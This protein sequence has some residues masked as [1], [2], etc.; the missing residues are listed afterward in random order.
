MAEAQ[1]EIGDG[2]DL[3][4][5]TEDAGDMRR[6]FLGRGQ[7]GQPDR[8]AHQHGVHAETRIA[9][10]KNQQGAG[11]RHFRNGATRMMQG[12]AGA[13]EIWFGRPRGA[14]CPC[15]MP[16]GTHILKRFLFVLSPVYPLWENCIWTKRL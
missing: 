8:F 6:R 7:F 14:A 2:N 12:I 13:Q 11:G 1:V 5:Q 3:A 16:H 9:Q 15:L 10:I 4:A